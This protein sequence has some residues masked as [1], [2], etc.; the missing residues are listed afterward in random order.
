ML[1]IEDAEFLDDPYPTLAALRRRHPVRW[2]EETGMFLAFDY[3]TCNAVL[4]D[5]RL[6]RLWRDREPVAEF[7]AFN[8]IHRNAL[9]EMEPPDHSRTRRL[10]SAH[11]TRG[12]SEALGD[13]VGEIANR[14]A[15]AIADTGADGGPVDLI[16]TFAQRLPVEVIGE[17]LGIPA[18]DRPRLAPWSHAIVKMYEPNPTDAQRTAAESAAAEFTEYLTTQIADRRRTPGDD[19]ISALVEVKSKDDDRLSEAELITNA[20]L[21]LNA[22]HEASVNVIGNGTLA[23]L[24][25]PNQWATLCAEPEVITTAIE[26]FIRYDAPLQL[27]ERTATKPVNLGTVVV[28]PGQKVATLL[29]A[30]NR[31]PAAFRDPDTFDIRRRDNPH[32]GFGA[33]IHFCLGAPLARV[34]LRQAFGVLTRRFPHL[35]LAGEPVRRPEFVIHGLSALPVTIR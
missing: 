9:L 5:R 13:R 19:L 2:D 33:G 28:Q 12:R 31:D 16:S 20:I 35:A 1:P 34:E 18:A 26:E 24:R 29:G 32:V 17:L 8:L 21:L 27:F 15:D 22:G 14:L 11:F 3:Q 4:R 25:H 30:A 7:A 10:M 23:L 6:G